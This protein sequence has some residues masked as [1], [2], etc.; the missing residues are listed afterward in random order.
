MLGE[1]IEIQR[2]LR[3]SAYTVQ[4]RSSVDVRSRRN[5]SGATSRFHSTSTECPSPETFLCHA[6]HKQPPPP[7]RP[8]LHSAYPPK[9]QL[10]SPFYHMHT[11]QADSF[12]RVLNLKVHPQ[13]LACLVCEVVTFSC[14]V[15]CR[16]L[17]SSTATSLLPCTTCFHSTLQETTQ[18]NKTIT[19]L[20][21]LQ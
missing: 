2:G 17:V 6:H 10:P 16:L 5:L 20:I 21:D 13:Q 12:L 1:G 7:M 3:S 4:L 18:R 19:V 9:P 15:P 11:P 14:V 8:L